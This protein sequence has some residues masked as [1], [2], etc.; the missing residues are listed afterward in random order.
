LGIKVWWGEGYAVGW[1]GVE[2]GVGVLVEGDVGDAVGLG[3]GVEGEVAGPG[4]WGGC[5]EGGLVGG[6]AGYKP[7]S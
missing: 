1:G 3:A 7:A 2:D 4:M 5:S 6:I